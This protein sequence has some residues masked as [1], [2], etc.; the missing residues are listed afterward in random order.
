MKTIT[1]FHIHAQRCW[2]MPGPNAKIKQ[3]ESLWKARR[4]CTRL[5]MY[6]STQYWSMYRFTKLNISWHHKFIYIMSQHTL[7][8][9]L[10]CFIWKKI[11]KVVY[12][13]AA[14][15]ILNCHS[16]INDWLRCARF[17]F[18]STSREINCDLFGV[19]QVEYNSNQSISWQQQQQWMLS[20]WLEC[21]AQCL[22]AHSSL[23]QRAA[24][25]CQSRVGQRRH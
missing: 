20:P 3:T 8:I 22:R 1:R 24:V 14:F 13:Y 5:H 25:E 2:L 4:R 9:E 16:A 10:H 18:L 15:Y 19:L 7:S 21:P 12:I 11:W 23:S 17:S 6:M